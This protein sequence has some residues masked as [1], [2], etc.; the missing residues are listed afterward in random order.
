MI[1]FDIKSL[2]QF[3][4]YASK[5]IAQQVCTLLKEATVAYDKGQPFMD[6]QTW[7][8]LYFQL[9]DWVNTHPNMLE[10]SFLDE[11]YFRTVSK[12]EKVEH[13]HPMLSLQ[14]TKSLNEI[15][16][17]CDDKKCIAMLKMDGL[18]C[19]LYYENGKLIKAETR[20]NG[21]I[22]E[23]ITHNAMVIPSIP[24]RIDFLGG[25]VVD[26]E[27]ICKY[28]DFEPFAAQYKN[29][30]NFAAGSIRLLDAKESHNRHLTFIAWDC[31][32]AMKRTYAEKDGVRLMM[33][34]ER[35]KTLSDELLF[36]KD[37]GF[38]IV[39]FILTPYDYH[40]SKI[41]YLDNLIDEFDYKLIFDI[42]IS[43]LKE[44][45]KTLNYPIDGI[46]FKYDDCD[47]YDSLG[48][49]AHHFRGGIAYKFYD[50][51]YDTILHDIEWTMGRTGVLTPVAVF[52]EVDTGDAKITRA[53]L[54]NISVMKEL[55]PYQWCKPMKLEIYLAN[56]IIP[57]VKSVDVLN[58]PGYRLDIPKVC[59]VCGGNTEIR[60][61]NDS[62]QLYCANPDCPGKLINRLDHF[63]GKKG[64]DIKGISK[65]TLEKL[66]DWGWVEKIED[67]FGLRIYRDEWIKKEGFG[68]KSVDKILNA[69]DEGRNT[70]FEK[71]LS[72]IGIPLIGQTQSKYLSQFSNTYAS[73]REKVDEK[74][75]FSQLDGF[76]EAKTNALLNFDYT[77][78]DKIY[79]YLTIAAPE[80]E[81]ATTSALTG[82]TFVITGR[83]E[84]FKN[85]DEIKEFIEQ[86]GGKVVGSI[87]SHTSYL[88]NND[89]NS[90][91][92]KNIAAKQ[93]GIPIID[94]E[95]LLAMI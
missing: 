85:R 76:A 69:I 8:N 61:E 79:T 80:R 27:I 70:S 13:N 26:G 19:S 55:Y 62:K 20:G 65:A 51:T 3:D 87:S 4:E 90:T 9:I 38:K 83:V 36:L 22:G 58:V 74:F 12:L 52:D 92:T 30:R 16:A 14:K 46:V 94:E 32:G 84:K 35:Y 7:D 88:V 31:L 41:D 59:P 60:Q 28:N 15:E 50:E 45:A 72:A 54:H 63:L 10:D 75:D 2:E 57:Q 89:I 44:S 21:Y 29:P 71:F 64:L 24:K 77:E 48:K 91:S 33:Y 11:I 53:N 82:K 18:T 73:L 5:E 68:V 95:T 17:F 23:D 25:L 93:R 1:N 43:S 66:I 56:M 39:P 34:E 40:K 6:D 49:T 37:L 67:I 86:N 81:E 78:A 47:Y 42:A